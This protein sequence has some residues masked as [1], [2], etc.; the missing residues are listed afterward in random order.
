MLSW[1]MS[2][3]K[4]RGSSGRL[5][6]EEKAES[7]QGTRLHNKK[8]ESSKHLLGKRR[9]D[10]PET[11]QSGLIIFLMQKIVQATRSEVGL[12]LSVA[13]R[14]KLFENVRVKGKNSRKAS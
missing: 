12:N 1:Q 2:A 3:I 4:P 9:T 14:E 11:S 6:C 10:S 13:C 5:F 8:L 7:P